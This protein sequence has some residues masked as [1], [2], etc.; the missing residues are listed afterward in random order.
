MQQLLLNI[1]TQKPASLDT[2]IVGNNEELVHVLHQF[3]SRSSKEHFAYI[4]G[5]SAVGKTH[6]LHALALNPATRYID[7]NADMDAFAF[8]ESI[9]LYLLDNCEKLAPEAQVAAFSLFNQVRENNGFLVTAGAVLPTLLPVL[10]DLKSRMSWGLVYR[11]HELTDEEKI[12]ALEKSAGTRGLTLSQG[13]LPYLITHYRRDMH[14]LSVI[15]DALDRYSLETQRA[16][17]LPLLLS[18]LQRSTETQT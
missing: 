15:L 5:E 2:F 11:V 18:L 3:A 10:N 9:T 17:T 7:E 8:D 13:V 16:I 1:S 12:A 14:S 4:W 6:L